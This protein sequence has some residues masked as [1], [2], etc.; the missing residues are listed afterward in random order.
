MPTLRAHNYNHRYD[1]RSLTCTQATHRPTTATQ[2]SHRW[3]AA[4]TP[5]ARAHASHAR[6]TLARH[7]RARSR[8]AQIH[9]RGRRRRRAA[10]RPQM[11]TARL[12]GEASSR[13]PISHMF[14]HSM[15]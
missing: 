1:A 15:G 7:L 3:H 12:T 13:E 6:T 11:R 9:R 5:C 2:M 8:F 10:I 4:P 14:A